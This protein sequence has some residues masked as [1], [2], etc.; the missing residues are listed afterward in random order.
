MLCSIA[1][2][3]DID[4]SHFNQTVAK[5]ATYWRSQ[6]VEIVNSTHDMFLQDGETS[7]RYFHHDWI[8]LLA[9]GT[10]RLLDSLNRVLPLVKD[11]ENCAFNGMKN[12]NKANVDGGSHAPQRNNRKQF[13][14]GKRTLLGRFPLMCFGCHEVGHKVAVC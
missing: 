14:V 9:S 12:L 7:T 11:I 6:K 10:K 8:N 3:T 2:R 13:Q 5:L 1:P 4:V